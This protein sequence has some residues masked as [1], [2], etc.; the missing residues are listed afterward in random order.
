MVYWY[1]KIFNNIK[2]EEEVNEFARLEIE[3]LFG[4]V[5]PIYNFTDKLIEEPLKNFTTP[6]IRIQDYITHEL[7]YGKI[8]GYFGISQDVKEASKLV[9]RLSYIREIYLIIKTTKSAQEIL[10]EIFPDG[11]IKKN[12]LFF[13]SQ[14]YLLFR[15][16]THQY[17][18]EK[19][20]YISKLSRNETEV[21]KNV[22]ILF[23][24][25][26]KDIYRIPSSINLTIGKRLQDYFANREEPSLYL[27]HYF[28][29]YKGKFHPKMVRALLNYI[30]PEDSG[31]I[32]DNFAGSGTLLVEANLL[33]LDSVGIEINPLSCLMSNVKCNALHFEL[34]EL[35]DYVDEY[36][37]NLKTE[38]QKFNA[39]N[40]KN[41]LF[42]ETPDDW[43]LNKS[44]ILG[45][46]LKDTMRME[47]KV[48][49]KVLIARRL[50]NN[51]HNDQFNDFLLLVLSGAISDV[52]RRT[53]NQFIDV[54]QSRLNN[55]F[56][57]LYLF[58][59]LNEVLKI[60][61]GKGKTYLADTRN[62]K[63]IINTE[64][65]NGIINSPPYA[66]ALDYI[67]ND[68]PQLVLLELTNSIDELGKNIIGNPRLNYVN[69]EIYRKT[70]EN[71]DLANYSQTAIKI[72]D[73][74]LSHN[75]TQAGLR[76]YKF[77]IDMI[78]TLKEMHRVLIKN[79][80]CVIIIGNN[81]YA[82]GDKYIEVPNDNVILEIGKKIGF[83]VDRI[84]DRK[85]QK[86]SE[87]IIREETVLI[88]QK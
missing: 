75:R 73:Y 35:K 56:L 57:R 59:K 68:Y 77:F 17:F 24:H 33:G 5:S 39:G 27:T 15:F 12:V 36:L 88:F 6:D 51:R 49:P 18:L 11:E 62:M 61:L 86:S 4:N 82:V 66:V 42:N 45:R 85:L 63:S 47:D 14:S 28:H 76:S 70:D 46:Q 26:T 52:A 22:E 80:K 34:E 1:F 48:I 74:L 38:V 87:G 58:K 67:K 31:L 20:E 54:F 40:D 21:N 2:N 3:S 69:K 53:T 83:K 7:A 65:V 44:T 30:Y 13:Q 81:H 19:S 79:C 16:I 78:E 10:K 29:P 9:K 84:I 71:G 32:L 60:K 43:L 50:L 64:T 72:T 8:Q 25:L 41:S 37:K 23:N 55:L